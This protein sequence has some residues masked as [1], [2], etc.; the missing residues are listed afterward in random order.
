MNLAGR[1][2]MSGGYL[3]V[4]LMGAT[5]VITSFTCTAPFVGSLLSVGASTGAMSRIVLGMGTF[6]LTMAVPFVVLSLVP[7]K[8]SAMPRSGEWMNTL[9]VTL[10]FVELAAALKFLSNADLAYQWQA[11]S[12][13]LFLI[14]WA[15]ILGIAALYLLGLIRYKGDSG[16]VGGGRLLSGTAFALLALYCFFGSLGNQLDFVMTAIAPNYSAPRLAGFGGGGG[17]EA[18]RGHAIVKDDLDAA[19]AAA[20]A[21]DKLVLVNFTG[22]T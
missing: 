22:H 6:G 3:G 8:L 4:F 16:E 15:G 7:G 14:L 21:D 9:K 10:G 18:S 11:L 17:G 20:L 5:L 1:A 13:E 12:R 19:V 2:R